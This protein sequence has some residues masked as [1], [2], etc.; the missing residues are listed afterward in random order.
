MGARVGK[1]CGRW[2]RLFWFGLHLFC[3]V[4]SIIHR[5]VWPLSFFSLPSA[6]L[7]MIR[8]SFAGGSINFGMYSIVEWL[9]IWCKLHFSNTFIQII[10]K[11][12]EKFYYPILSQIETN[13]KY[14]FQ[15][16]NLLPPKFELFCFGWSQETTMT[17]KIRILNARYF[18]HY[19]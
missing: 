18:S 19:I 7:R 1:W 15:V 3:S 2:V 17:F 8:D 10:F 9:S 12:Y 6:I 16:P 5:H 14:V 4:R 11:I 13:N